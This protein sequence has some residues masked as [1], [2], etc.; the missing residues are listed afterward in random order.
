MI[1]H[2]WKLHTFVSS[3][4]EVAG[5]HTAANLG[6]VLDSILKEWKICNKVV[7][8]TTDNGSNIV[9]AMSEMGFLN[10]PCVGHTLNLAVLRYAMS[11][12]L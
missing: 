4:E 2:D 12:V 10:M 8:T 7:G 9:K 6:K 3:T 5:E 11:T 1:D